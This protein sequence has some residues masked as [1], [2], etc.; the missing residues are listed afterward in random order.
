MSRPF[1]SV[2]TPTYNRTQ[3]ISRLVDCYKAQTYPKES[4]EW[5]ILDDGQEPCKDLIAKETK[6][7]P[8]IIY[9]YK[10]E[11]MNIGE[12]RNILNKLAKGEII[13]CMD[14]DDYYSPHRVLHVVEEFSK[15]P[16]IK[17]AGSSEM[18]MYYTDTK[19]I[20]KLG[21]Y[22]SRHATNGTLA[23]RSTYA[24]THKY[25]EMVVYSE[26][27]SFLDEYTHP[28]IQLNP[29]KVMLVMSHSE[30]TFN[31]DKLREKETPFVKKTELTLEGFICDEALKRKFIA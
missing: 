27:R 7:L 18:Y 10:D 24:K 6:G 19:V 31:K 3:F 28:M 5:I 13:V 11:K 4:M 12:K 9:I 23:Y 25:D 26:E 21:P 1:V 30:N 14:D 8:N 22:S 15:N 29:M 17:L 2:L 16:K 20:Y